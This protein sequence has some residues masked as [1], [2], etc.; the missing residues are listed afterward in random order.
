[1][2]KMDV[3]HVLF[4]TAAHH[5]LEA[6]SLSETKTENSPLK[7]QANR[8][9][10]FISHGSDITEPFLDCCNSVWG[11]F[12]PPPCYF[13][14][15]GHWAFKRSTGFGYHGVVTEVE[16]QRLNNVGRIIFGA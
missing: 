12:M 1:M 2:Q 8:T 16:I 10:T 7:A 13:G 4:V 14:Y 15:G 11:V 3:H 6:A 5:R 9:F